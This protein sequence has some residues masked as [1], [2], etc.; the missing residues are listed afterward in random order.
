NT[1]KK[2]STFIL[3]TSYQLGKENQPSSSQTSSTNKTVLSLESR[4]RTSSQTNVNIT[5]NQISQPTI[6]T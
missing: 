5:T 2:G 1:K 3:T 6:K 4:N